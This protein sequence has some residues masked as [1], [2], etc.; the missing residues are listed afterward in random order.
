MFARKV[1][2]LFL[3]LAEELNLKGLTGNTSLNTNEKAVAKPLERK[4]KTSGKHH[5]T[6]M[7]EKNFEDPLEVT[8][9]SVSAANTGVVKVS[10]TDVEDLAEQVKSLIAKSKNRTVDGKQMAKVCTVCGKEGMGSAIKDHIEANHLEGVS[11]PC[12]YCEKRFRS[13][14]GLRQ[15]CTK[16]HK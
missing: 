2:K 7:E 1:L 6:K 10:I 13:R 16:D 15:H 14:N 5:V 11:L 3:A 9:S 4:K 12:I 8:E